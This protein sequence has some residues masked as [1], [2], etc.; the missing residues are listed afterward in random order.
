MQSSGYWEP[1]DS[2]V[3]VDGIRAR[4]RKL[5]DPELIEYGK[6]CAF[7]C[8][9]KQNFGKPPLEAW[10]VQLDEARAEWRRHS[11]SIAPP[12]IRASFCTPKSS[13]PS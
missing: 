7:L 11:A 10:T 1:L 6:S 5:L 12:I 4:L 9:R 13:R 3:D 8:S 2:A